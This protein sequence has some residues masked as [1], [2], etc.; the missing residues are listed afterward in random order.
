MIL[1]KTWLKK[2]N[3]V[4]DWTRNSVAFASGYC[5]AHCQS[6]QH[7]N[8]VLA[9]P[10]SPNQAFKIAIISIATFKYAANS[11]RSKL[12][13]IAAS[14]IWDK[15]DPNPAKHPDY[16]ANIIPKTY[17]E[18][19]PLFAKDEDDKLSF[20]KYVD[21]EIP[22]GTNKPPMGSMYSMSDSELAEVRKWITENL[23][24]GFI[25]ASSFSCASF[26]LCNN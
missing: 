12:F 4:I 17:H 8:L 10:E 20:H 15:L 24:K 2:H 22:I 3:P 16:P 6:I 26:I 9:K 25:R 1:G 11:A 19:L 7:T 23:S 5:Q 13:V 18:Y 14:A 21:H